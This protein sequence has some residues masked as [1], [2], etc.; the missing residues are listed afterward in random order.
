MPPT[1]GIDI[2][3]LLQPPYLLA[4]NFRGRCCADRLAARCLPPVKPANDFRQLI[5]VIL[6][7]VMR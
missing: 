2:L 6:G 1:Q 3:P 4:G 7:P 5:Y